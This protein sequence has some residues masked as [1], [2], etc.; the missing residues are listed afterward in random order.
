[1]IKQGTDVERPVSHR[2]LDAEREVSLIESRLAELEKEK[3]RLI[4]QLAELRPE[5][6]SPALPRSV[7]AAKELDE[8][9]HLSPSEEKIRLFRSLFRGREDVYPLRWQNQKTGRSGYSPACR[10]EWV[11]GICKKPKVKCGDCSS[12]EFLPVT[13]GVIRDHPVGH[14]R[15]E[16]R[17]FTIGV[18]PLLADET[19]WFLAVDFDKQTWPDD[20]HAFIDTCQAH[21]I[22]AALERS[23]SG[24][25]AHAWIFFSGP[26]PATDARRIGTWMISETMERYPGIGFE[27]YDRLFPSQDTLPTG[28]FG[29]LIAL[30]LQGHSRK[31]GNAIFVDSKLIPF[32]DQWL[33]LSRIER[34]APQLVRQMSHEAWDSGRVVPI[35]RALT[36]DGDR[37]WEKP[38]KNKSEPAIE[39]VP[40]RIDVVLA[41]QIYIP[42]RDLPSGLVTRLIRLAAFQNPEFYSA[43]AMRLSTYGKPRI[44]TCAQDYPEH[45]GLPR[46]CGAEALGLLQE[47]GAEVRVEQRREAGTAIDVS[48]NGN[49]DPQQEEAVERLAA[50]EI[51]VLVA[52]TA[53]GKTVVAARL[54]ADRGRSTLVVVHRQQLLEQWLERLATFLDIDSHNLG[55]VGGGTK[56]PSGVVDVALIQSLVRRGE[57]SDI[58]ASYGHLIVDECHHLSAVSFEAVA[59]A[60]YAKYVLGLTATVTRKDGHHPIVLM[61]C[62]PIRHRVAARKQADE[63][64]FSHQV[65]QRF[66]DFTMP[67]NNEGEN[68]IAIHKIYAG[69]AEDEDRNE[70]IFNDVLSVLEEG[71]SPLVLTERRAHL[72]YLVERFRG[73]AKN[74]VVLKGGM[75][76][77]QLMAS[78][79]KLASIPE[80]EERLIVAT[81]RYLGEGFDDARLDTLFLAMPIS[82]KGT[83]A[84]Y[85]GRLHRL[86]HEKT[87]VVVYD[88]VDHRVPTLV[89]M[90]ERRLRGYRALGYELINAQV[91]RNEV[92]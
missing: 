65:I 63:R 21:G 13:D 15:N 36:E 80:A 64:P 61:Q 45:I 70:L 14:G 41:N 76:K 68:R 55:R 31:S 5:T 26:V 38:D 35:R 22:P 3:R 48:F 20:A 88:Y 69:L 86:H 10:N 50:H 12:R 19:C 46:G 2:E 39:G 54:I 84:Q 42:K 78:L 7:R 53:F 44:I 56:K 8:V 4:A 91:G 73:F 33:Y 32:E 71:R 75:G 81:G 29:N 25:G 74:L 17:A 40:S 18:Y 51:G 89:R 57:V 59:R 28:G 16:N 90:A 30:P 37:P 34:L 85:A 77:R 87:E 62:G 43:Q 58:V 1:L 82:W 66:T 23:R 60:S 92:D 6:A 11:P 72:E 67:A 49:L 24:N 47:L 79:E 83:L 9:H 27:S 52:P